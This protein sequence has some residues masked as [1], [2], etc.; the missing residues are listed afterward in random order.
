MKTQQARIYR[1]PYLLRGKS[2]KQSGI[3]LIEMLF[4]ILL[5]C[6]IFYG[7]VQGAHWG[8]LHGTWLGVHTT[9][10]IIFVAS[11]LRDG[12]SISFTRSDLSPKELRKIPSKSNKISNNNSIFVRVVRRC[13]KRRF[14]KNGVACFS[15]MLNAHF[16]VASE[17][18]S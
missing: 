8:A 4:G 2:R 5:L 12:G 9:E 13:L 7:L 6:G 18:Y 10:C 3:T 17:I 15:R 1:K 11:E 16:G 14:S